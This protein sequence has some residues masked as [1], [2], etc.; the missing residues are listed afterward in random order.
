[1]KRLKS[2]LDVCVTLLVA[3]TAGLV[4]WKQFAPAGTLQGRA[5]QV[6]DVSGSIP[7]ELATSTRGVGQVALVE[8]ADFECPFCGRHA[9]DV[10]PEIVKT[11]IDTG[12]AR[13]VFLNFPLENHPR[14]EPASAAALCA[15]KQGEFWGM[16]DLLF[17]DQ[18][19]LED[20]D[21]HDRA[22]KLDLDVARFA[23]CVNGGEVK[24]LIERHMD[25]AR[26]LGVEGTPAFFVGLVQKDGSVALKKRING[27]VPFSVFR[28]A[29]IAVAPDELKVR[30][31][32][33]AS[34]GS[35]SAAGYQQ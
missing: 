14:A 25:V 28:S 21:L 18:K 9:R 7:A 32:D 2:V 17:L 31:R 29:I 34:V 16:H 33:V 30:L 6:E 15:G 26:S 35:S 11:F 5:S 22:R 23:Q 27:A 8:L 19:A 10:E 1:M 24:P 4:I 12:L 13:Q 3:V 20:S